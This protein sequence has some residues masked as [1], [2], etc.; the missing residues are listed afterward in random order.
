MKDKLV[1]LQEA[2]SIVRDG[3]K[4]AMSSAFTWSPMAALRELTRRGVKELHV[5]CRGGS[6][7]VDYLVGT[8]QA[9]IVESCSLGFAPFARVCPNFDRLVKAGK[10]FAKDNT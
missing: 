7:N 5:I 10:V 3:D 4:L 2:V 8:G 9:A 6:I 1:S